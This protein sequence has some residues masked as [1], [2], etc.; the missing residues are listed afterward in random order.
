MKIVGLTGSIATGK[1]TIATICRQ[2]GFRCIIQAG[3]CMMLAPHG[4]AVRQILAS[5][6]ATTYGDIG[7]ED[8]GIN[9]PALG[10]IVFNHPELR[11]QLEEI[12]HPLVV[13]IAEICN[14]ANKAATCCDV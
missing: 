1:S 3:L 5:F 7:S 4:Q 2:L 9:R 8:S 11:E 14:T 12:I 6:S 13:S 10:K